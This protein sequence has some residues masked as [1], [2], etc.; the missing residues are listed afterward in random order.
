MLVQKEETE[1]E[2]ERERERDEQSK[3]E[4]QWKGNVRTVLTYHDVSSERLDD[5]C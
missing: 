1:R 3:G 5:T 4:E 2:R